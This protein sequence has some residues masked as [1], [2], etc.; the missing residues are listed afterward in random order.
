VNVLKL[1]TIVEDFMFHRPTKASDNH[2]DNPGTGMPYLLRHGMS[3]GPEWKPPS[4][5]N[6]TL[7]SNIEGEFT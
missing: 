1:A 3:S 6:V 2:G 5:F 4:R 7:P